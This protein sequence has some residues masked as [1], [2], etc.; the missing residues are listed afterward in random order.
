METFW[1]ALSILQWAIISIWMFAVLKDK[2][3]TVFDIRPALGVTTRAV[4]IKITYN[5]LPLA[6]SGGFGTQ[7]CQTKIKV[8]WNTKT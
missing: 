2:F 5:V 3:E 8:K 4:A 7:N 1:M 6:V